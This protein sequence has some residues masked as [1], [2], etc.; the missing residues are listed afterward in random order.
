MRFTDDAI[1]PLMGIALPEMIARLG[2]GSRRVPARSPEYGRYVPPSWAVITFPNQTDILLEQR[3]DRGALRW[4]WLLF[5]QL[6]LL[7]QN[8]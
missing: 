2:M 3:L 5:C 1:I 7:P 8:R 6:L 4:W